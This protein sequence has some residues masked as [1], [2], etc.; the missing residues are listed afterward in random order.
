MLSAGN[1]RYT[2]DFTASVFDENQRNIG[3]ETLYMKDVKV[4]GAGQLY[5][6]LRLT[7][8]YLITFLLT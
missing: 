3:S 6:I 4:G 1:W 2:K 8:E 5:L 7:I